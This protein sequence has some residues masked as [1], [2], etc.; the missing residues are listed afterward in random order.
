MR[1][2]KG[3]IEWARGFGKRDIEKNLDVT[4]ETIFQAGSVSK[5][6]FALSTMLLSQSGEIN[7]DTDVNDYLQ[8]WK[9]PK[10]GK[11]QPRI[12]L[13]QLLSHTAGTNVHGFLGY[14]IDEEIPTVPQLLSGQYPSNSSPIV[15]NTL[16]GLSYRY[17]GGGIVVA[18]LT[19]EEAINQ[20]FH[21][22]IH[23]TVMV[24]LEL[25]KSTYN[26]YLSK[27]LEFKAATG[28]TYKN[29]PMKNR[30]HIYPEAAAGGLWSNPSELG[31][32]F[33]EMQ[34]A[35][36]GKSDLIDKKTALELLNPQLKDSPVGL[37]FFLYGEGES[38]RFG[39]RGWD[40][41]FLTKVVAYKNYGKGAVIMLN[42]NEG[43]SLLDEILRSIAIEYNWPDYSPD[44][45]NYENLEGHHLKSLEGQYLSATDEKVSISIDKNGG[46]MMKCLNQDSI[47]LFSK[48]GNLNFGNPNLNINVFFK[49]QELIINQ[50]NRAF[51]FKKTTYNK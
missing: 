30:Y 47:K 15:V 50:N 44:P 43:S 42:S 36:S 13:R 5:P 41:G 46:I 10:V 37:G 39:H 2:T 6:V 8:S 12:T 20:P 51:S 38:A 14:S 45:I 24:P 4:P 33:I 34:K 35:L 19:I 1:D 21:E 49:D 31:K 25:E 7:I 17:S 27:E 40:E 22:V 26:Q 16:P 32:I 28:Y 18:Q 23:N 48:G 9:V 3:K 29:I 11:W